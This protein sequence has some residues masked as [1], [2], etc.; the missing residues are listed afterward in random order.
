MGTRH[1]Q[2]SLKLTY[3]PVSL[4]EGVKN[5]YKLGVSTPCPQ[6]QKKGDKER[7]N[8]AECS[9]SEKYVF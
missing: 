4:R 7:E 1:I 2:F 5:T 6:N 8:D 9:E 3:L